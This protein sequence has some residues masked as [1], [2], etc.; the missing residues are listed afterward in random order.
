MT[1]FVTVVN[2]VPKSEGHRAP[3]LVGVL[4]GLWRCYVVLRYSLSCKIRWGFSGLRKIA[5]LAWAISASISVVAFARCAVRLSKG[6][7]FAMLCLVAAGLG[8]VCLG[9]AVGTASQAMR[10][11]VFAGPVFVNPDYGGE[12]GLTKNVG[13]VGGADL[14]I[15]QVL[16][17]IE[18]SIEFRA[19]VSSG[20]VSDQY[21]YNGG[22]RLEFDYG[23]FHPY[24][25]FLMGYGK[26]IF[27]G[28]TGSY[29]QNNSGVFTYGGGLDFALDRRWAI[30][31][32]VAQQRWRL[33]M[34]TPPFYPTAVS[35]GVRYRFSFKNRIY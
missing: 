35:V 31:M 2:H 1:E 8:P 14:N 16:G 26:I 19:L 23:R 9:Q 4:K 5:L 15:G 10:L 27:V 21:S 30:R 7:G 6:A 24:G 32:D 13:A 33:G 3:G 17:R 11:Q 18:P 20:T 22:P 29:T 34:A 25:I 12:S 28:A